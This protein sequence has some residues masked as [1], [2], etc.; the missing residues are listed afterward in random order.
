MERLSDI[1]PNYIEK[2]FKQAPEYEYKPVKYDPFEVFKPS[3]TYLQLIIKDL[4]NQC[5]GLIERKRQ[6]SGDEDSRVFEF[7]GLQQLHEKLLRRINDYSFRAKYPDGRSK[8]GK[9]SI[10]PGDIAK[11]KAVPIQDFCDFKLKRQGS[12][13][14][15]RCPFH[16]ERTGSFIVYTGQNSWWCYGCSQGGDVITFIEKLKNLK[17]IEAVKYLTNK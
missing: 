17:F 7:P 10:G 15:G 14:N 1:L 12:R 2:R 8:N 9:R 11:A 4:R 3:K 16:D 13:L 5:Y 6:A